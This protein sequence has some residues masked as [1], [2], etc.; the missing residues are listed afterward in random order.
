MR[1]SN[2]AFLGFL[3]S[4]FWGLGQEIAASYATETTN[5]QQQNLAIPQWQDAEGVSRQKTPQWS[6]IR[7]E[8]VQNQPGWSAIAP[9][10]ALSST[11]PKAQDLGLASI[12]SVPSRQIQ[13]NLVR[14][15]PLI[16]V[17]DHQMIKP[18]PNL[19]KSLDSSYS[20]IMTKYVK[21]SR[22]ILQNANIIPNS[23][24]GVNN[25]ASNL[26]TSPTVLAIANPRLNVHQVLNVIESQDAIA[27]KTTTNHQHINSENSTVNPILGIIRPTNAGVWLAS[28]TTAKQTPNQQPSPDELAQSQSPDLLV[29]A[30]PPMYQPDEGEYEQILEELKGKEEQKDEEVPFGDTRRGSPA[31]TIANPHAFG[32]DAW[33]VFMSGGYQATT[34][35]ADG[36]D[37][38]GLGIGIGVGDARK[39]VGLELSYT[40]ASFGGSR[41]FGSG[42]FNAKLHRRI[43]ETAAVAVGW[44]G[45]VNIGGDNDFEDSPYITFSKI[46]KTRPDISSPLSRVALTGGCG[47]GQ[48]ASVGAIAADYN[49]FNCF[50]SAAL[51]IVEPVSFIAEWTS[52]DFGLGVS[53]AP[54]K[55]FPL[56]IT[57]AVRDLFG[58]SDSD[59]R[60]VLGVGLGWKF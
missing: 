7:P 25:Q 19:I 60:F 13:P 33:T 20:K 57:P 23:S 50:G 55:S 41:D 18:Q 36:T 15:Q 49:E 52:Q 22:K 40:F 39:A 58:N 3:A 34:R 51:R 59:P 31:I 8:V 32:A 43:G 35:Y 42:G 56:V 53:F 28:E 5:L 29:P 2:L 11:T 48:F 46:F 44:N 9:K 54:F 21:N 38:G 27:P 17:S 26:V 16:A 24:I 47:G 10:P 45:F 30:T 14:N 37:D 12:P 4:V 1:I 6:D